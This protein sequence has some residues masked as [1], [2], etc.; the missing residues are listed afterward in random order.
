MIATA[1]CSL[2][3]RI[4]TI[5]G[6]LNFIDLAGSERIEKS[7]VDSARFKEAQTINKTLTAVGDVIY[8]L[9]ARSAHVPIRTSKL[10]HLL[11]DSLSMFDLILCLL[12]SC[13]EYTRLLIQNVSVWREKRNYYGRDLNF[14]LLVSRSTSYAVGHQ[15]STH[16][17]A[18]MAANR[19]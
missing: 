18:P 14:H 4:I 19:I 9:R 6:K 13:C 10:T 15:A 1:Q 8:S 5:S 7:T 17:T 12:D 11:Q 3:E 2:N 16:M